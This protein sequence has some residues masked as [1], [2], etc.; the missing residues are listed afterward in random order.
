MKKGTIVQSHLNKT[1][2]IKFNDVDWTKNDISAG[3]KITEK[4][5]EDIQLSE[6]NYRDKNLDYFLRKKG[7]GSKE[8]ISKEEFINE[9]KTSILTR[10]ISQSKLNKVNGGGGYFEK[11]RMKRRKIERSGDEDFS[12]S[13]SQSKRE[14]IYSS[15][16]TDRKSVV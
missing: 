7:K 9:A 2:V 10:K 15:N 5:L 6:K 8:R 12:K 11:M 1:A 3:E 4:L 14:T 13:R 16:L